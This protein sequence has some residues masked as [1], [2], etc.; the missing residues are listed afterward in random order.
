[1]ARENKKMQPSG[2]Q[3]EMTVV[4]LRFRGGSDSLQKGFETVSQALAALGPTP[5]HHQRRLPPVL[6]AAPTELPGTERN[7][8][9]LEGE[10]T[11]EDAEVSEVSPAQLQQRPQVCQ[12]QI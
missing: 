1:M 2:E 10:G 7:S 12:T 5:V 11:F 3:E 6:S 9:S 8:G 4:I